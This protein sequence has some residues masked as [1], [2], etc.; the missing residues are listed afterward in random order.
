LL[1]GA[2]KIVLEEQLILELRLFE[3]AGILGHPVVTLGQVLVDQT[4]KCGAGVGWE[5]LDGHYFGF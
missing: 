1:E 4:E 3:S 2:C 5:E